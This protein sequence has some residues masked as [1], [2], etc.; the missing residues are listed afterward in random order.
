MT[1]PSAQAASN[2]PCE[3][4]QDP[5]VVTNPPGLTSIA[6]R[7][8]DF[9]GFRRALLRGLDGEK[10]LQAWRPTAGD[11]GLQFLE[12]WAYLADVLTFYNERIAN[13]AYLRTAQFPESIAGLVGLLG[14]LPAPGLAATGQVGAIRT[15]TR[16]SEPLV[17]PAGMQL[18]STASAGVAAQTFE[19]AAASFPGPS[20]VTAALPPDPALSL[21]GA[22]AS[23]GPASVLLAGKVTGGKAGDHLLLVHKGWAGADDRWSAVI[24]DAITPETD[25]ATGAKNTRISFTDAAVWGTT[26]AQLSLHAGGSILTTR[27]GVL[28]AAAAALA[29]TA[30]VTQTPHAPA[31]SPSHLVGAALIPKALTITSLAGAWYR[32]QA[33]PQPASRQATEYRLLKPTASAPQWSQQGAYL[34]TRNHT[35]AA[36]SGSWDYSVPTSGSGQNGWRWCGKC[37]GLFFAL[38]PTLG[39]CPAG[40][41]HTDPATSGSATYFLPHNIAGDGSNQDGWRWCRKCQGLLFGTGGVCPAGG[42]HDTSGSFNYVLHHLQP[43]DPVPA[44]EQ[45]EWRWCNRCSGLFFGPNTNLS[46]CPADK[47]YFNLSSTVRAIKRGDLVFLDGATQSPSLLGVVNT[48]TDQLAKIPFPQKLTPQPPDLVAPYTALDLTTTDAGT[49]ARLHF[50]TTITAR[51]GFRDVGTVLPNPVATLPALPATVTVPTGFTL[52]AGVSTA[53]LENAT[54]AGTVVRVAPS[55]ASTD[56]TTLLALTPAV[57]DQ[58]QFD[59]PLQVPLRLVFDLVSISRGATVKNEVLGNGNAALA[60]QRFTLKKSPLTYLASGAGRAAALQVYV[61]GIRWSEVPSLYDQPASAQV[62]VVERSPDQH[63]TVRFGDGVNG[64]RLSSGAGNVVATYRYGSGAAS[65]PAG[66]LTTIVSRQPNLAA[67][68]NPVAVAGG[69]D[70]QRPEDVKVDAPASVFAFGRAIS[71]MDYQVVAAGAAGVSRVKAYWTF[72]AAQQRTLVKIYV[73]DDAGGVT[74]ATQALA[75]SDDP[76]RPVAV[77]AASAI[78]VAASATLVVAADRVVDDVLAAATAA[79]TDPTNGAFSPTQMGIGQWLYRSHLTAALSVPGV[80]AVHHLTVTW[81]APAPPPLPL[82][83]LRR[84]DEV[85]DPGEGAYFQ[86]PNGNLTLTG[87]ADD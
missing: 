57:G 6:D 39:V 45:P 51:Y 13:E 79:F 68:H 61:D 83:Y 82:L 38:G 63:A 28:A 86:L 80:V 77:A 20:D 37:Q 35:D 67:I 60:N 31:R 64:A 66:R 42:A 29:R 15:K 2:C 30:T 85:A 73:N 14:Y 10:A 26:P 1:T 55:K 72:D 12:W 27:P 62:Y 33:P 9:T 75:G 24:V 52:P 40:G 74:T 18:S 44:S 32:D 81:T 19:A 25:P 58:T 41:A 11:L 71:A 70:P 17:I 78:D 56:T 21:R 3:H 4:T 23:A 5:Q 69:A 87:V 54:G 22:G 34:P 16:P 36:T 49:L 65:P 84:L 48:A 43:G 53:L 7:V 46:V 8:D 47:T 59:P 50:D 76:N